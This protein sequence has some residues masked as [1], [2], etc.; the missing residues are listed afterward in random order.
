MFRFTI[1]DVLWLM[2]VVAMG[3]AWWMQ[4]RSERETTRQRE[5]KW[6]RIAIEVTEKVLDAIEKSRTAATKPAPLPVP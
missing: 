5:I 2:V 1:R 6:K 4:V 3:V